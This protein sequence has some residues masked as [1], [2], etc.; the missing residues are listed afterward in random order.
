[1]KINCLAIDDEPLALQQLS[2]Y[3][4]KTPFFELQASCKS[5]FEAMKVLSE[6]EV[7]LMF[8]DIQMPGLSGIDFV[9]LWGKKLKFIF[10]T[11]YE[12]FALE[13]FKV[14]ALDYI[15]KPFG[16]EEFL[17]SAKKA[18]DYFELFERAKKSQPVGEEYLF[19]KSEYKLRK[20]KL[21]DI[22]YIEGLKEYVKIVVVNEKPILSLLTMKHLEEKLSPN[23]F[24]RVHRSFIVNLNHINT[25]ER[26]RII[27][28]EM[29]IPVSE[30]YKD[31][32]QKF[33]GFNFI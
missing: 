16:Y 1:M 14:D 12:Q 31:N 8:V 23:Q 18:Q 17:K 10:T 7:D 25:I 2:G 22:I 32:F 15:L 29:I 6:K 4:Q 21:S 28:G 13:G 3:I 33:L 27:F 30:Q 24:M 5:A 19:V 26:G 9:K 20:I 11:A